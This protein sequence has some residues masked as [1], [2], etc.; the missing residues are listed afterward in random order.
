MSL[1]SKYFTP[2]DGSELNIR[3]ISETIIWLDLLFFKSKH[4]LS[5]CV[6]FY[7]FI[8]KSLCV[9][10]GGGLDALIEY[11]LVFFPLPPC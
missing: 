2:T 1:I 3:L 6:T 8:S 10:V 5:T 9:C 4:K 7:L 11:G